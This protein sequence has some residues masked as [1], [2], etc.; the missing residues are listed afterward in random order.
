MVHIVVLVLLDYSILQNLQRKLINNETRNNIFS[1]HEKGEI[2]DDFK[3]V[4]HAVGKQA[5]LVEDNE[6]NAEIAMLVLQDMG[7][8][9]DWVS[10]GA[11][12]VENFGV[13]ETGYYSLVIM[14]IMMPVM[15]GIEATKKIREEFPDYI[16]IPV[17]AFTANAVEESR[18]L[19]LKEG[20]DDFLAK[21]VKSA[22]LETI[23][24][25]WLPKEKIVQL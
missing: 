16:D 18:Q 24:R 13:S 6:I 21:P 2:M 20:M 8:K 3:D 4:K 23:L 9:V 12:A 25:K 22:D 15:D 19:L 7:F 14:D 1:V 11:E 10:N 5:L 17:I